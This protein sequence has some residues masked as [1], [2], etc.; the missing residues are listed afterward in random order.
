MTPYIDYINTNTTLDPM[1]DMYLVDASGGSLIATLPDIN[2]T[3]GLYF[4]IRRVD[5][6]TANT[7]TIQA[8]NNQL[9]DNFVSF[10][11]LGPNNGLVFTSYGNAWYTVGGSN[12]GT[13]YSVS[14]SSYN[15][16]NRVPN[17]VVSDTTATTLT[18]FLY[19]G[20]NYY[21]T[22]PIRASIVYGV[23]NTTADTTAFTLQLVDTL[24]NNV[25]ADFGTITNTGTD[26]S[27]F[28]NVLSTFDNV[29]AG[30]T[31]INIVATLVSGS[32]VIL[33]AFSIVYN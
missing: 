3:D 18:T 30:E 20:T 17:V 14:F 9:I 22:Y 2:F 4:N 6:I 11:R 31:P 33:R 27:Y 5:S 16:T 28:T 19:K 21:G 7:I 26:A 10:K 12:S 8:V 32:P 23:D 24:T 29:P 13:E 1:Y 15:G 25:V